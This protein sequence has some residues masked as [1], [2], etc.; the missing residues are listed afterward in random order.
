MQASITSSTLSLILIFDL[1]EAS[2]YLI[3]YSFARLSPYSTETSLSSFKSILFPTSTL[4]TSVVSR[5]GEAC[6]SIDWLHPRFLSTIWRFRRS[7]CA[8]SVTLKHWNI[9][10]LHRHRPT[11]R[12]SQSVNVL[13]L[14]PILSWPDL[15]QLYPK[16]FPKF[17]SLTFTSIWTSFG[18]NLKYKYVFWNPE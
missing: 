3:P 4:T 7:R 8:L 13:N 12:R 10:A 16:V 1:A 17:D 5:S 2:Q 9:R 18:Q 15:F 11:C 14:S 6:Y